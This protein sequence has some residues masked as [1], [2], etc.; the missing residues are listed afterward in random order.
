MAATKPTAKPLPFAGID[1]DKL[2][3]A[4]QR[5]LDAFASAS[6]IVVDGVKA[7]AQRQSEMFQTSVDLLISAGQ[8]AWTGKPMDFKPGDQIESA[9]SNYQTAVA[10]AKEL[11]EIALKAHAEA[12]DVLTRCVM[13]NIDDLKSLAKAA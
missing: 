11:T 4:Q 8:T 3:A 1:G 5:N 2:I 6:Q 9:K 13:A 7:I 12:S 10:N